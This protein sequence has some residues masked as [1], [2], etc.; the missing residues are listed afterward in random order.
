MLNITN[1]QINV[2]QTKMRYHNT[3]VRMAIITKSKLINAGGG[4]EKSVPSYTFGGNVNWY[5][6]Y[7]KKVCRYLRKLNIE[8]L[9]DPAIPF[10]GL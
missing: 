6:H 4:M 2:N 7:G 8:L 3:P 10:M 9:Y 1:N 5:N